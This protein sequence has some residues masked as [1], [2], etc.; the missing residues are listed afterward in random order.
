VPVASAAR[1]AALPPAI[2]AAAA[3]AE[4]AARPEPR[5][6]GHSV[7]PAPGTAVRSAR[8]APRPI[9]PPQALR[10]VVRDLNAAT[11]GRTAGAL[12]VR[13]RVAVPGVPLA[14]TLDRRG[15]RLHQ[16]RVRR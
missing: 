5:P 15:L 1:R 4:A 7:A 14:F 12:G 10:L 13:E 2:V 11:V 6:A 8:N 3:P 16:R 9:T